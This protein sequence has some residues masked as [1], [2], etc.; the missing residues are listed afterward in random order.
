MLIPEIMR[1]ARSQ[2]IRNLGIALFNQ[3]EYTEALV[4]FEESLLINQSDIKTRQYRG[5]CKCLLASEHLEN[6]QEIHEAILD[7]K[8][9]LDQIDYTSQITLQ[10]LQQ[11]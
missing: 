3:G 4:K 1:Y 7:F 8:T 9:V 10:T 11:R 2:D 5:M 6:T